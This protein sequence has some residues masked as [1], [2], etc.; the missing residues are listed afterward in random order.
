MGLDAPGNTAPRDR[1][2]GLDAQ[3]AAPGRCWRWPQL[4]PSTTGWSPSGTAITGIVRCFPVLA[5][6]VVSMTSG[7]PDSQPEKACLPR[8]R[9]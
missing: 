9:R 4:D 2:L 7:S 3:V 1:G 5:P 8:V 6:V